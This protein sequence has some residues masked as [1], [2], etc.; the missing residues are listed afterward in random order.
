MTLAPIIIFVYKRPIETLETLQ[1]LAENHLIE[2]S[3]LYIFADAPKLDASTDDLEK[4]QKVQEIISRRSWCKRT[5]IVRRDTNF[6]LAQN[7]IAG[8]SSIVKKHGKV[9][10]LEDDIVPNKFFLQYMNQALEVFANDEKVPE[11]FFIP[12]PDCWG[13]ATWNDRWELFE[14]D[15]NLLLT[16][17]RER[18]LISKFNLLGRYDFEQMLVNQIAGKNNSWAIRWQALAY[19]NN[20]LALYPK[21]SVVKNIGMD[22]DATHGG[23][24]AIHLGSVEANGPIHVQKLRV[25]ESKLA[26]DLMLDSYSRI[27]SVKK[28][29]MFK[30]IKGRFGL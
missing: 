1:A 4:I 21:F 23:Q 12:I 24:N 30:F 28:R 10:V 19:V 5:E 8:V 3:E 22:A 7:I 2:E 27:F 17:L 11:T 20:W 13:W 18:N 9:I 29:S 6:G 14:E 16:Q 25:E 15:G 26:M